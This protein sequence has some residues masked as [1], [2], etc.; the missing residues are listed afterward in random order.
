M[1]AFD[2]WA[3]GKVTSTGYASNE[4]RFSLSSSWPSLKGMARDLTT[5]LPRWILA[6]VAVAGI[7]VRF[8]RH[9]S[10]T[11]GEKKTAARRDAHVGPC[12]SLVGWAL[13]SLS[14]LQLDGVPDQW[15]PGR[16]WSVHR[17]RHPLLL[18]GDG[19]HCLARGVAP[20]ATAPTPRMGP[21]RRPRR[22]G[23]AVVQFDVRR[24][25]RQ[26]RRWSRSWTRRP[27]P[28]DVA[29]RTRR[30]GRHTAQ[31]SNHPRGL[32]LDRVPPVLSAGRRRG[33][34]PTGERDNQ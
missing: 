18:A 15:K 5:S 4:I 20:H 7:T 33:P 13:G 14:Q 31:G 29:R 32:R 9:R 10:S 24:R 26:R 11:D 30:L 16:D 34:P 27:V 23:G 22:S 3:Y 28:L 17:P 2:Q 25:H 12:S 21:H 8:W 19:S 6:S 1:L